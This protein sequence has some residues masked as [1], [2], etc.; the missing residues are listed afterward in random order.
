M[1]KT[2]ENQQTREDFS[3]L[4]YA[5]GVFTRFGMFEITKTQP[6]RKVCVYV[7]L[8][9]VCSATVVRVSITLRKP[10]RCMLRA[11]DWSSLPG[12]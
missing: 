6:Q 10:R 8:S 4:R 7:G 5:L 1:R 3:I 9:L 12:D 11:S 2:L